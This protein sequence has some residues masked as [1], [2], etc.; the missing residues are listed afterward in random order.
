[1]SHF[2]GT[3]NGTAKTQATRQGSKTSG[4]LT[5]CASHEG[6]IKC[7]AYVNNH[8]IDCVEVRKTTWNGRG[9]QI[10]LYDGPIGLKP[11][12]TP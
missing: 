2:Y 3:V 10:L 6:A 9:D 5:V 4:L 1:M 11:Q 12:N 8:G 7:D